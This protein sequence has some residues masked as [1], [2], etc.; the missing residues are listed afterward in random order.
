MILSL[1]AALL[2]VILY[3][4][5]VYALDHFS[6]LSI[7][8]LVMMVVLGML[9]AVACLG[10]FRL[11]DPVISTKVSD[12]LYP[13]L[14]EMVKAIPL[15]ALATRKRMVFFIDSIICGA[16]VGGGFSILENFL[17][18]FL[19]EPMAIGTI[20]FRSLEVALI[21]M[22]CSAMVA[23]ARMFIVRLASRRLLGMRVKNSDRLV[24]LVLFVAA[25]LL[26]ILHNNLQM[27]NPVIQFVLVF[28]NMMGLLLWTYEYDANMI[29][30]WLD[31]GMD[32]QVKLLQDIKDGHLGETPTGEF[33]MGIKESFTPEAFFDILCFVQLNVELTVAAK[34]RFMLKEAGLDT[35]IPDEQ[36]QDILSQYKEYKTLEKRLGQSAKMS[37]APVVKFYPADRM[38]LDELL[39]L[40]RK[41]S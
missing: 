19:G 1:I 29:H 40:C 17:Y 28:G 9:A 15:L 37:I 18:L 34:A 4:A 35:P 33:L 3:I 5:V 30:R 12:Y 36:K 6:L 25:P 26:H 13:A 11:L 14:E 39:S 31:R 2:P 38:A 16:A 22:G 20:L 27:E 10:L 8:R 41:K 23:E 32:K 24:V 7:S 21:H